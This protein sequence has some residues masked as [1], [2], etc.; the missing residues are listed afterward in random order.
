MERVPASILLTSKNHSP[1]YYTYYEIFMQRAG[2]KREI[3]WTSKAME[4][5]GIASNMDG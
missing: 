3:H 4:A 5:L 2:N 1:H